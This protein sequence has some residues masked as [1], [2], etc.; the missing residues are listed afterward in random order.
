MEAKE[1][2]LSLKEAWKAAE[3]DK[4]NQISEQIEQFLSSLDETERTQVLTTV[5]QDMERMRQEAQ[6]LSIINIRQKVE[7]VLPF[8]SVSSL[9]RQYFNR[10]PQWF[11]QRLNGNIVNGK[12]AQFTQI[13]LKTLSQALQDIAN[14]LQAVAKVL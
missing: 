8:I 1:K 12:T 13:E 2:F 10:T 3:G 6:E 4:R 5:H 7:A 14:R 11:Y 9:S